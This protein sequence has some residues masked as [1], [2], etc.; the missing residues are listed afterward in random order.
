MMDERFMKIKFVLRNKINLSHDQD[1][2]HAARVR[3]SVRKCAIST[4]QACHRILKCLTFLFNRGP[5]DFWP[6]PS[7]MFGNVRFPQGHEFLL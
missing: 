6:R 7:T 5:R 1:T 2:I 3:V 4:W